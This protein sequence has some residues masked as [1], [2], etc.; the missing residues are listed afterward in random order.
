[1]AIAPGFDVHR[2][3]G[4]LQAVGHPL[5]MAHHVGA[6][7]IAADAGEHALA[8]RPRAGDRV[9]L[10]VA[11]HLVVDPLR[12]AAQ[13]QFAQCRQVAGRE[14]VADRALGLVRHVDLAVAQPLD[15]VLRRQVDQLDVVGLVDDRV[16][17]RLAHADAGDARDDIVQAFDV[18][19]IERGVDVDAGGDQFLDIHVAFGMPAA[20]R[21][22]VCQ[23]IDQGQLRTARQQRVEIHL[24]QRAPAIL[25]WSARDDFQAVEQRLGFSAPV[26]LDHA[27]D[28][29]D[30][31]LEAR[32]CGGEHL[33]GLADA[34][35]GAEEELQPTTRA[36]LRGLPTARR[37]RAFLRGMFDRPNRPLSLHRHGPACPGHR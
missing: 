17:H 36:L 28:D 37:V 12:G 3:P 29:I 35:R 13:C 20:G 31:F 7:G 24:R 30:A 8:G 15:Q 4:R 2:G 5:G 19:D 26:G 11:D 27:D 10:H 23:F 16:R 21:V 34:G 6:A 14:I 9:R 25:H 33:V 22:G 32:A 1:M 18:L